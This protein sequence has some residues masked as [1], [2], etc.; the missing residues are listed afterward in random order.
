MIVAGSTMDQRQHMA[1]ARIHRDKTGRV[2]A[3]GQWKQFPP[4]ATLNF[5][6]LE[7]A[8][9]GYMRRFTELHNPQLL[10]QFERAQR[11]RN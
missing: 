6:L 9:A 2:R 10:A 3:V 4:E 8:W 11:E 5:F 1:V 7:S